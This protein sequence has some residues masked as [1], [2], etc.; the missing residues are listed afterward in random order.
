MHTEQPAQS[1]K[2]V[3]E[4]ASTWRTLYSLCL[5]PVTAKPWE[6]TVGKQVSLQSDSGWTC[7]RLD[8]WGAPSSLWPASSLNP[9]PVAI[10]THVSLH[11]R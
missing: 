3:S 5:S 9:V 10:L 1:L 6:G 8:C 7:R 4:L 11:L 2:G